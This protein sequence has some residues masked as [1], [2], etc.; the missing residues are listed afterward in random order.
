MEYFCLPLEYEARRRL[1]FARQSLRRTDRHGFGKDGGG[2]RPGGK[3]APPVPPSWR[4]DQ[5]AEVLLRG[6][7]CP[8]EDGPRD[9][10]GLH[11]EG[12]GRHQDSVQSLRRLPREEEVSQVHEGALTRDAT[13]PCRRLSPHTSSPRRLLAAGLLMG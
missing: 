3:L 5:D 12:P 7:G 4:P 8:G 13:R 1:A 10:K 11:G 9:G 2:F 6:R